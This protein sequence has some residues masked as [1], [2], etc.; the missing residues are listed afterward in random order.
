LARVRP[1]TKKHGPAAVVGQGGGD[2][3][4]LWAG[5]DVLLFCVVDW[6]RAWVEVVP[7]PPLTWETVFGIESRRLLSR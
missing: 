1:D 5:D 6:A 7:L 4:L 2:A 3:A